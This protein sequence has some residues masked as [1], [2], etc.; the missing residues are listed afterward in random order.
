MKKFTNSESGQGLTEYAVVLCL[1]AIA[2]IGGMALFGGA[3]KGKLAA[4][5]GA[6]AGKKKEEVNSADNMAKS[7]ATK[8]TEKASKVKGNTTIDGGDTFDIESLGGG[9]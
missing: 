2:S 1:V 3:V 7:A 4:L 9:S 5:T 6:V 8:A